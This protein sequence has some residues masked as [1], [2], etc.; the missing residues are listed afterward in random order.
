MGAGFQCAA[1]P[2]HERG[3]AD[4]LRAGL[5]LGLGAQAL[6]ALGVGVG[7]EGAEAHGLL[8]RAVEHGGERD[9]HVGEREL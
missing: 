8:G 9:P 5:L 4:R 7:R 3:H 1:Q 6:D 2:M